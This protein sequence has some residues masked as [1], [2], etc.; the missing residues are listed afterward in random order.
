M[1]LVL[2]HEKLKSTKACKACC[3]TAVHDSRCPVYLERQG[4]ETLLGA[5]TS[6]YVN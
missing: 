1:R 4:K 2:E 5:K 6:G 3:G